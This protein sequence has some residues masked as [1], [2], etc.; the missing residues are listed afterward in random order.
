MK[1]SKRM[2]AYVFVAAIVLGMTSCEIRTGSS[3]SWQWKLATSATD[4]HHFINGLGAYTE[5]H[6]VVSVAAT[7]AGFYVFYRDDQTATSDWGWRQAASA[8]DA[9]NFLNRTG[10]Y[11]GDPVA[12][13]K[14]AYKAN[15]E[16]YLFYRGSSADASWGWKQTT[17]PDDL[18]SF[19][20]GVESY[21]TP[22]EGMIGGLS[23]NEILM[24]YRSDL[25]GQGD[26]RWKLS[27][28]TDDAYEFLNGLGAYDEPVDDAKIFAAANGHFFIFYRR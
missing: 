20:N 23:E 16:L 2:L 24:F 17:S 6:A 9:N 1:W 25:T 15:G 18:H 28:T 26:W 5:P 4:V 3:T 21:A 19:I 10:P 22:R 7:S 8:D 12:E 14:F 13:A 27:T 11:T